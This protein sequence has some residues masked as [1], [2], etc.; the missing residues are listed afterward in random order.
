MPLRR[1]RSAEAVLVC[2]FHDRCGPE[3]TPCAA[4]AKGRSA[5]CHAHFKNLDNAK[6]GLRVLNELIKHPAPTTPRRKHLG[7]ILG[8]LVG[9]KSQFEREGAYQVFLA[10]ISTE[11]RRTEPYK[12][13]TP[14]TESTDI[15]SE[16]DFA[17]Y[18]TVWLKLLL[19]SA[20]IRGY[21]LR[22][23]FLARAA[24]APT[25]QAP[26]SAAAATARAE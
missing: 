11:F 25:A 3:C 4:S 8:S 5:S 17:F 13:V 20:E 12:E 22:D 21:I 6:L 1:A 18:A 14:E 23:D 2:R 10:P 9:L 15:T 26:S 7:C 19:D 16:D 24:V